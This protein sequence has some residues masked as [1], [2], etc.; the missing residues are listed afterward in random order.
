MDAKRSPRKSTIFGAGIGIAIGVAV[1]MLLPA[2][3]RGADS[4]PARQFNR[5]S[6][7]T[8]DPDATPSLVGGVVPADPKQWS[9]IFYALIGKDFCTATLVG[10]RVLLTAAHCVQGSLKIAIGTGKD[11]NE[12][13]CT[14]SPDFSSD[15]TADWALCKMQ[16]SIAGAKAETINADLSAV[17]SQNEL[18]LTGFGCMVASGPG[19]SGT[20]SIGPATVVSTPNGTNYIATFGAV[21]A[22]YG[23]SG[24]PAFVGSDT[25]KPATRSLVSINSRGNSAT[26][27]LL[28]SIATH[29]AICFFQKWALDNHLVINGQAGALGDCPQ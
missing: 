20:F 14:A 1:W 25:S 6:D 16:R 8:I 29:T 28:S 11:K 18:L 15:T 10:D 26:T 5:V 19:N 22:C 13:D 27:T 17:E 2:V 3:G 12:G 9:G 4:P 21:A 24:G 23:D 7:L